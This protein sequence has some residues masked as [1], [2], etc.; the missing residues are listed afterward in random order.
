MKLSLRLLRNFIVVAE[1]RHFGRAAERLNMTQPPLSQQ[2]K[3]LEERLGAS[4]FERTTRSVQLTA[5]GKLL[6]KQGR[7]L[8]AESDDLELS[9]RRAA[10]GKAGTLA[11]GFV[12]TASC[13]V[14]PR[15]MAAYRQRY[16]DVDLTLKPMHSYVALEELRVGRI[17]AAF[18]RPSDAALLDPGFDFTIA[19]REPMYAALPLH[20]P[21]SR[22]KS[23]PLQV[24]EGMPFVG[25]APQDGR[26]FYEMTMGLFTQH[27]VRPNVVYESVMPTMFAIV[28]A[29]MGVA[30][31]PA[32]AAGT[33][34]KGLC[35]RPLRV[36]GEPIEAVMHVARRA[37][38][39]SPAVRA[40]IEISSIVPG[41]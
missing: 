3:R 35:Y 21:L 14:L 36:A 13:E 30:L 11:I 17:D 39:E 29:G 6:L 5:A 20:H 10:Q 23:V 22:R 15:T 27:R 26:Y 34:R 18:V 38:D 2:M 16:A 1:E 37:D 28:E 12:N 4:L 33:R 19:A 41:H 25:Y 32:S 9:V 8:V 7:R 40:F 24:L 31:V